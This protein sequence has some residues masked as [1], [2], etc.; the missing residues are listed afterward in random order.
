ME[1][2]SAYFNQDRALKHHWML[3]GKDGKKWAYFDKIGKN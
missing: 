2:I 1:P 3:F